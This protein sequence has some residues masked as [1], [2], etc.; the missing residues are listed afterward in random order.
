ME[1][2]IYI[3][4]TN[5]C[6]LNCAHC[7]NAI[8]HD[9]QYMSDQTLDNVRKF[10]IKFCAQHNSEEDVIN[11]QL[12][13]GEPMLY[14]LDKL[15]SFVDSLK[16][17]PILWSITTN[18]TYKVLKKHIDF[19]KKML[20]YDEKPYIMTSWDYD[21]RFTPQQLKVWK[22][23]VKKLVKNGIVVQPIVCL[24]NKLIE[25]VSPKQLFEMMDELGVNNINFERLTKTGNAADGSLSPT[26][27]Q[28]D[29][30]LFEAYKYVKFNEGKYVP[31][32]EQI[33]DSVNGFLTGCRARQC[34]LTVTT[35]NPNGTV[36]ACPNTANI[37]TGIL[38]DDGTIQYKS[39][40]QNY[41]ISFE[42]RKD[43]KCFVCEYY[44]YC[45]GECC[46]LKRDETGCPG[47]KS[48]YKYI[49]EGNRI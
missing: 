35:I 23:N 26:N 9:T 48:I 44:K 25:N 45:N 18:L 41:L 32:F 40:Q 2:T 6:N 8:M 21:I 12:H 17:Y 42:K 20:P 33:D 34:M 28:V 30:W 46:Q 14:D 22:A 11:V 19:F 7:Y 38:K 3:K 4:L 43:F 36:S 13:G 15:N 31:L 47:L 5:D 37:T 16:D 39:L 1:Y 29:Q 10:L 49:F 27:A 24:T